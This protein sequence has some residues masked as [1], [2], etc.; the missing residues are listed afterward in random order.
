M[1]SI[2]SRCRFPFQ[3]SCFP[4]ERR[5]VAKKIPNCWAA[6]ESR[7]KV[8]SFSCFSSEFPDVL[9]DPI[10]RHSSSLRHHC[11]IQRAYENGPPP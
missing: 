3:M 1:M 9:R 2:F 11:H 10:Y 7:R 4:L 6:F 5:S 8:T